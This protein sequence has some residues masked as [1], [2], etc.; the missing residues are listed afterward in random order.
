LAHAGATVL[1]TIGC[2]ADANPGLPRGLPGVP[3]HGEKVARETAR[4]LAG[5]LRAL[6]P[7]TTANFRRIELTFD[8]PVTREELERR[9]V[10]GARVQTAYTATKLLERLDQGKTLPST[11]P[12]PVQTWQF[13]RDLAM[14][15][16]GGEVVSEYSLRLKRELDASRLWVH[17][18]ANHVPCYI[19]SARMFPEGGYE[20]EGSMDY[21]GWPTRLARTTEDQ[22]VGEV[23]SLLPPE[24]A[25]R[26][27]P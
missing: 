15:F 19:P 8:H 24:M 27:R 20:V 10:K 2:G 26:G 17:A 7:V 13:G 1:V 5:P 25:A 6:G 3:V 18:Y 12:Y 21:Y 16:L 14:V 23:R 9:R 22:I 11:V 4:L